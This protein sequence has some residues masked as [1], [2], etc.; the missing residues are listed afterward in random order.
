MASKASEYYF[1][2]D[3]A[4]AADAR[5][6]AD[7]PR[8]LAGRTRRI[9]QHLTGDPLDDGE[10]PPLNA[11]ARIGHNH[12]GPPFGSAFRHP[13]A[14]MTGKKDNAGNLQQ[15][16]DNNVC[17]L[18]AGTTDNPT[19]FSIRDWIIWVPPFWRP[20]NGDMPPYGKL[21]LKLYGFVSSAVNSDFEV[22]C[23]ARE[24]FGES[25][26]PTSQTMRLSTTTEAAATDIDDEPF[27][28]TVGGYNAIN[29]SIA[30]PSAQ[31]VTITALSICQTVKRR[32]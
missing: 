7:I 2:P 11:D 3:S 24:L 22:T 32:H 31:D 18:A 16:A 19:S 15:V 29:I 1:L 13:V 17:S 25:G 14:W 12:R 28:F 20:T 9:Y 23:S 10:P 5:A 30:N 21:Y 8:S 6:T 4:F 27:I 26:S